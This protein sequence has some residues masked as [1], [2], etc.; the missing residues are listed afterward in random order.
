[1]VEVLAGAIEEAD[2]VDDVIAV[3]FGASLVT[4]EECG[5]SVVL[6]VLKDD[7]SSVVWFIHVVDACGYIRSRFPLTEVKCKIAS[8]EEALFQPTERDSSRIDT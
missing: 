2:V 5:A 3:G 4:E 1:M 8:S 6:S 7:G